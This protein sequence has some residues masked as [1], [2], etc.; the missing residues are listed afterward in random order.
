LLRKKKKMTVL[1]IKSHGSHFALAKLVF[2][3]Q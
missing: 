2:D 3:F 1:C